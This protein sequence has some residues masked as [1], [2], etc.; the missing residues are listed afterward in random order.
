M[1]V[2]KNNPMITIQDSFLISEA[3]TDGYISRG[4]SFYPAVPDEVVSSKQKTVVLQIFSKKG[5]R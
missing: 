2:Y 5:K 1:D 3:S 4:I